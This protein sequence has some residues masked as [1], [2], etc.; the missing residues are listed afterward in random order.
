MT[1]K[2]ADPERKRDATADA[3]AADFSR[4]E[5]FEMLSNQRRRYVVHYLRTHEGKS[6]LRDLARTIA[7][8]ENDKP[9]DEVTSQERRRVYN[10]LQQVHLPKLDE[11]GVVEFD[12]DRSTVSAS[13]NLADLEVYLEIVP[14]R[15]IPWSHY[16]LLLGAFCASV[17]LAAWTGLY[18]FGHIPGS[19]LLGGA[20][21]LLT[22][23]G[24]AHA[25][26]SRKMRLGGRERPPSV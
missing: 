6:E 16:Y 25:Y 1:A 7:A 23:S 19:L 9:P 13:E 24:L 4:E 10:G 21:L 22:C 5:V 15:E 12:A 11:V 26:Y 8:W 3:V 17:A 18:P 20:A 2:T 14:G